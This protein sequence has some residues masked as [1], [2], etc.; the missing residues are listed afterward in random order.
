MSRPRREMCSAYMEWAKMR[1]H[2]RFNLATSGVTD[3]P[4][5]QLPVRLDDLEL[6]GPSY[7]G[8]E[9]LQL[10]LARKCR[11]PA[12]CVVAATGTSMANHLA[13]AATLEP[14]DGVLIE[15]PTYELLLA[16]AEYLG[17]RIC[18]FPDRKSVV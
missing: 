18:R 10:R 11:V 16:V 12:E 3:F 9:P 13:M 17:A 14:G 15:H 7:Y 1:S 5:A 8:Y 6:S 2:A 4:L